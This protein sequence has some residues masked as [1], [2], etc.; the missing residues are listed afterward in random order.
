[1]SVVV[2][3]RGK[4]EAKY[5]NTCL[6]YFWVVTVAELRVRE[7][8]YECNGVKNIVLGALEVEILN[9]HAFAHEHGLVY[10]FLHI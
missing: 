4:S 9:V 1:M 6:H 2:V 10:K 7:H 5:V 3:A 8:L